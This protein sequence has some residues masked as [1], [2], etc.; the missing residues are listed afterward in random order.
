M[1]DDD[2]FLPLIYSVKRRVNVLDLIAELLDPATFSTILRSGLR[3]RGIA[4][5]GLVAL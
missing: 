4:H 1:D 3:L 5:Q 2:R